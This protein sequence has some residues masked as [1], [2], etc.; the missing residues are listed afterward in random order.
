[1]FQ[2][3][4][5]A[6][7]LERQGKEILHFE[8]G[9]PDFDT[10]ENIVQSAI[11]SLRNGETHY[12][13]SSGLLE[14][15]KAASEVTLRSREFKPDLDSSRLMEIKQKYGLDEFVLYVSNICIKTFSN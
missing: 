1:M 6:R 7:E 10:P 14:F 13:P 3:L 12:A 2:I 9:D 15:K 5:V 4:A 11:E 8:L